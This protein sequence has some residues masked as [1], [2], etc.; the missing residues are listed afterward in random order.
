[1]ANTSGKAY[2]LTILSPIKP[3]H[4]N[5]VAHSDEIRARIDDWNFLSNSPM[6]QVPETYLCRFF[7]LDD[8]FT[9]SQ[10]GPD[11][12]GTISDFLA[13]FSDTVRLNALPREDHLQSKY[14]VF[15]CNFHGDL[16]TYLRGMWNAIGPELKQIWEYC[17]AFD[18]VKDADSFIAYMQ[19][20]QL[21]ASLFFNGSTDDPLQEQLKSLYVKQEFGKF[22][23]DHQGLPAAQLQ[24]AYQ[25]FIQ[26][27]EP[28][29]LAAPSWAPG[30]YNFR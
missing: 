5:E 29:N 18:Q 9:Q 26:R 7:V 23:I 20:C 30:Q 27:I 2:A 14:L 16:D 1:M 6:S 21:K 13:I 17:Y 22:V 19:Q 8:V 24:Q 28:K 25:A 12:Y 4:I 10:G 3:G 11:F 15:S